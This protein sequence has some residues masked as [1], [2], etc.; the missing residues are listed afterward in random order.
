MY[1][2]KENK[3][4]K[5][6]I[7]P[8]KKIFLNKYIPRWQC[9]S[10]WAWQSWS[11]TSVGERSSLVS[12]R[13]GTSWTGSTSVSSR[14]APSDS[15][16]WSRATQSIRSAHPRFS[17]F[18]YKSKSSTKVRIYFITIGTLLKEK[19][20]FSSFIRKLRRD[21]V[22]SH[23]W[24]TASSYSHIWQNI[25]AFPHILGSPSSYMTLQPIP[26]SEF[27]YMYEENFFSFLTVQFILNNYCTDSSANTVQHEECEQ[28]E[29]F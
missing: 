29:L 11:A 13:A 4:K 16:T 6:G 7:S 5:S 1:C 10:P 19:S 22:Q 18:C 2:M 20:I 23:L 17:K 27:P 25:C 24:L 3:C 28:S 14:S 15:G 12:G 8:P 26:F 9:R 21:R